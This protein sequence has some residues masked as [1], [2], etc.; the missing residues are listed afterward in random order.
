MT[1]QK[2]LRQ[3][4]QYLWVR[5]K[6]LACDISGP[7]G[8]EWAMK[9]GTE[10]GLDAS[11]LVFRGFLKE[12]NRVCAEL[13]ALG[14]E[15]W[16]ELRKTSYPYPDREDIYTRFDR[17][18][19]AV[20]KAL[21]GPKENVWI[22]FGYEET[23]DLEFTQK[24]IVILRGKFYDESSDSLVSRTKFGVGKHWTEWRDEL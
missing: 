19:K 15:E 12:T 21:Q 17:L 20:K 8:L 24:E 13:Y 10:I 7:G 6:I 2:T 22:L 5:T 3:T 11:A 9:K 23:K 1:K 14:D 18:Y 4:L 16:I